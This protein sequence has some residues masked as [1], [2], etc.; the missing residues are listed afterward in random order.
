MSW[1]GTYVAKDAAAGDHIPVPSLSKVLL[2]DRYEVRRWCQRL[3][4]T[5]T[6]LR[7]AVAKVGDDPT[8]VRTALLR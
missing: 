1:E 7:A 4:C 6:Q 5:E 3:I 2:N 8:A